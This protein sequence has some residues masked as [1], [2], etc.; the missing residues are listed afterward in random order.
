MTRLFIYLK[1]IFNMKRNFW[2]LLLLT[3]LHTSACGNRNQA[4]ASP[5]PP[6]E[7][8]SEPDN[9]DLLQTLQGRWQSES[10]STYV[11][12]IADSKMRHINGGKLTIETDIEVDG[13]CAN[14]S[15]QGAAASEDGWCFLEKGQFDVQCHLVKKCDPNALQFVAIGAANGILSF[16]KIK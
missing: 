15:C 7:S 4:Q 16:R 12:E 1:I 8:K 6:E 10:D 3:M 9:N 2:I 14:N 5:P 13:S 11:L